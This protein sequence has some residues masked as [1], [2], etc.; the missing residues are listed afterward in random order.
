MWP[1]LVMWPEMIR[2]MFGLLVEGPLYFKI[3]LGLRHVMVIDT[4]FRMCGMSLDTEGY[5]TG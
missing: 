1:H 3:Y 5:V 2:K 4:F